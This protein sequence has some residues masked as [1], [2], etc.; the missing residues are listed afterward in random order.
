MSRLTLV[1]QATAPDT[2]GTNQVVVYAN[3]NGELCTKND[4]GLA[5]VAPAYTSGSWTPVLKFGG[6]TT[7][8][9]YTHQWGLYCIVAEMCFVEGGFT[10]SSK[11]AAVGAATVTGLPF[12][13]RNLTG[14]YV[15]LLGQW[16]N[17]TT[18]L[19]SMIGSIYINDTVFDVNG[20]AAA[21][22]SRVGLAN[23]DF[24]NNTVLRF[25]GAYIV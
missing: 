5:R 12:A 18:A 10:L 23:T 7:G 11:G 2:P 25:S 21:G 22:T 13:A 16:L 1:E 20:L 6:A 17:M 19:V 24:A 3:A 4:A 15:P 8:I 9:T 14:A